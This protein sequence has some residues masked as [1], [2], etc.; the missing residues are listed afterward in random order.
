[1]TEDELDTEG[2]SAT[3]AKVEIAEA[4]GAPVQAEAGKIVIAFP[5]GARVRIEGSV[6]PSALA[7][8]LEAAAR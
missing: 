4:A 5:S 2:I 3:F 6:D 7:A 1:M 8:V